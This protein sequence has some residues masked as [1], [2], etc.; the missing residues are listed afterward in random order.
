MC[1]Y[2]AHLRPPQRYFGG[3]VGTTSEVLK[4]RQVLGTCRTPP[5]PPPRGPD[6]PVALHAQPG[7]A[8]PG[9]AEG[10]TH[11]LCAAQ[12]AR[13]VR[14]AHL[15]GRAE[16]ARQALQAACHVQR[17]DRGERPAQGVPRKDDLWNKRL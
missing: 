3:T 2:F 1:P 15:A 10:H 9:R 7:A 4:T 6:V 5:P 13:R 17:A 11:H 16:E 14:L 12:G 8:H